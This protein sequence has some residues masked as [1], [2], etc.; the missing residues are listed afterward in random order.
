MLQ[1]F[2]EIN[3]IPRKENIGIVCCSLLEILLLFKIWA[4]L[5]HNLSSLPNVCGISGMWANLHRNLAETCR[6]IFTSKGKQPGH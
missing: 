3:G 5:G 4:L 2:R 1:K 6:Y